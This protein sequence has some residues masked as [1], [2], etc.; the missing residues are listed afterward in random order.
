MELALRRAYGYAF[1]PKIRK[2]AGFGMGDLVVDAQGVTCDDS[3][4][5]DSGCPTL[6]TTPSD[7]G[8]TL[9]TTPATGAPITV[10]DSSGIV[11]T[12]DANGNCCDP[13]QNCQVGPPS[14]AT[15]VPA[16]TTGTKAASATAANQSAATLVASLAA[17]AAAVAKTATG[18]SG[19][20]QCGNGTAV[21]VGSKCPGAVGTSVCPS[22]L[23]LVGTTCTASLVPGLSNSS[24]VMIGIALVALMAF[25]G[26]K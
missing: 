25:S 18:T 9:T 5:T 23:T 19:S 20:I 14:V 1:G 15:S 17:A 26:K 13:S 12:C 21:P 4:M 16:G 10:I 24:L 8:T 6:D 7:I 22:G 11:W 3:M 2:R